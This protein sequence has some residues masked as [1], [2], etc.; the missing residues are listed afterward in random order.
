MGDRLESFTL[1]IDAQNVYNSARSS[2]FTKDD[3]SNYG[4]INPKL[5]ADL[6]VSKSPLSITRKLHEVRIYS[7]RPN[8]NKDPTTHAAHMRQCI[9]WQKCGATVI[10]RDLRYPIDWPRSRAQEKGIDVAIAIDFVAFALDKTHHVGILA[11]CDT[12]LVP[13]LEF[14]NTKC[15][16]NCKIE[17]VGFRNTDGERRLH[18]RGKNTWCYWIGRDEYNK[19]ADLTSYGKEE[20]HTQLN[21][22][23]PQA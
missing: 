10:T 18:V 22:G 1:F 19:I 3:S 6:I 11:S 21:L 9:A 2:F 15:G 16:E 17:V 7:G 8:A 4:Q 20:P 13:A 12:D 5:L 14:V 23:L